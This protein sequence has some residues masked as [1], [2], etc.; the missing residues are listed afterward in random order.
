MKCPACGESVLDAEE[1]RSLNALMREFNQQFKPTIVGQG[2]E[3]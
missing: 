1:P 3:A 2:P